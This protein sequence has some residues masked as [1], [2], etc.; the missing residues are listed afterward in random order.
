[1]ANIGKCIRIALAYK[2]WKQGDLAKKLRVQPAAISNLATNRTSPNIDTVQN[3]AA[4]F[5][6]KLSEFIA[7]GEDA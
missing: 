2:G 7:L 3:L 4:A 1:M 5:D 6:M